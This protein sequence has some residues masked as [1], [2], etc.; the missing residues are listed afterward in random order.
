MAFIGVL[1]SWLILARNAL[2]A[3]LASSAASVAFSSSAC[4]ASRA[5]SAAFRASILL[6][7]PTTSS[8]VAARVADQVLLV[9]DPA[10]G[11]VLLAEPVFGEMLTGL[12]QPRLL[13]LEGLEIVG[14]D[15]PPPE[16]GVLEIFV[17]AVAEQA[18]DVV[19]DE[20]GGEIAAGLEAVDHRRRGAE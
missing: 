13:G 16:I 5:R 7:D 1:I 4:A 2:L 14:M 10:I 8:G 15:V 20:G 3:S 6:H 17:G 9:A 19:A 18:V 11:A 12:E